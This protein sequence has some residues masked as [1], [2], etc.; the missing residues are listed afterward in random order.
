[1]LQKASLK[2]KEKN[3]DFLICGDLMK[4]LTS[5]LL[6]LTLLFGCTYQKNKIIKGKWISKSEINNKKYDNYG[7]TIDYK[8]IDC[9]NNICQYKMRIN[10]SSDKIKPIWAIEKVYCDTLEI[11]QIESDS[12]KR[13]LPRRALKFN[14]DGDTFALKICQ[15]KS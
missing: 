8:Y 13:L 11:Q 6:F 4:R 5:C 15:E 1:M 10:F 7:T 3:V 14:D 12:D 9:I 2:L